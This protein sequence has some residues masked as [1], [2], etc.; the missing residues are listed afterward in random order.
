MK[1]T[2]SIIA[3]LALVFGM[4]Q[5]KKAETPQS[6]TDEGIQVTFTA[7]YGGERTSFNPANGSFTWSTGT[8][9]YIYVGGS[10]PTGCLGTLYATG[11]GGNTLTFTGTLTTT[12]NKGETLHFFYLGKGRNGS[13][14]TSLDFSSQDGNL[15]NLTNYHVAVGSCTYNGSTNFSATLEPLVAFAYFDLSDFAGETVYLYGEDVYA[16]PTIDYRNGTIAK[17]TNGYINIGTANNGKYVALIPSTSVSSTEFETTVEF[18]STSYTGSLEFKR[19]IFAGRY[20]TANGNAL[21]VEA[22]P[23]A[24]VFTVDPQGT[25]VQFSLGNLQYNK[26]T[27][28]WSF[29]DHQYDI[30]ETDGQ[31]VGEDYEDQDIVSLFGWGCTG[32]QDYD[33]NSEQLYYQPYSTS[34]DNVYYPGVH[35][36]PTSYGEYHLTVGCYSDWGY[37]ADE[38]ELDDQ[39]GWRTLS[40]DEWRWLLGCNGETEGTECREGP[41]F[42]N[43]TIS[44]PGGG[45]CYGLI[46]FPDG[47]SAFGSYAYN[48]S[49]GVSSV[50]EVDWSAMESAGAVFLPAAGERYGTEVGS[51]GVMGKY[52]SSQALDNNNGRCVYFNSGYMDAVYYGYRRDGYSVRLVREI[53]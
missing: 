19:G 49:D 12:P 52:W 22:T 6:T 35:Y 30:V 40:G 4:T 44:L 9:E 18:G 3:A 39:T 50:S 34:L 25:T 17:G 51:V 47:F 8:T 31:D 53:R 23:A 24:H 11:N 38:A 29:M 42:L 21:A 26:S 1:K 37:V 14:V 5:Y 13:A 2:L 28:E 45:S 48:D 33:H 16:T 41:R 15:V 36:G 20:Y 46:V 7:T 10:E 27:G 43:A 32:Y